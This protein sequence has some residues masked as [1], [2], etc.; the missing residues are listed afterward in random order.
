MAKG[1]RRLILCGICYKPECKFSR[2]V[3]ED[4]NEV[5]GDD[6]TQDIIEDLTN[7][8]LEQQHDELDRLEAS[9]L[10]VE[11]REQRIEAAIEEIGNDVEIV[12]FDDL[13]GRITQAKT[14]EQS[15]LETVK[16]L[17][18]EDLLKGMMEQV[19]R[20]NEGEQ[21]NRH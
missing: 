16:D 4:G 11:E 8:W 20:P 21:R 6:I 15:K 7:L 9:R 19:E 18:P 12:N 10:T 5:I 13:L 14:E 2:W 17:S 3:D 1:T